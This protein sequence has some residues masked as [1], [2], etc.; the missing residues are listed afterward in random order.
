MFPSPAIHDSPGTGL[1]FKYSSITSPVG[2]I[3][4]TLFSPNSLQGLSSGS[5][6]GFVK[7]SEV[8]KEQGSA[9]GRFCL[10]ASCQA[11]SVIAWIG[12]VIKAPGGCP[13]ALGILSPIS[14]SP[15]SNQFPG[16]SIFKQRGPDRVYC[17]RLGIEIFDIPIPAPLKPIPAHVK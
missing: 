2:A 17:R 3:Q 6:K 13:D 8:E 16:R 15:N 1:D 14:A 11:K 10:R 7:R 5:C 4:I 9:G 12:G